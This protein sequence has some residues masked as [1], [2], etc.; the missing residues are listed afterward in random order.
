MEHVK[1]VRTDQV[2]EGFPMDFDCY[3]KNCEP[4]RPGSY[5][6]VILFAK[7]TETK[8]GDGALLVSLGV[9]R[10]GDPTRDAQEDGGMIRVDAM[11]KNGTSWLDNYMEV[12]D[13]KNLHG[14]FDPRSHRAM[15]VLVEMDVE[16]Y[17]NKDRNKVTRF[18]KARK[19]N[20]ISSGNGDRQ[21]RG[22]KAKGNPFDGEEEEHGRGR[23][24]EPVRDR[25]RD[26]EERRRRDERG[27]RYDEDR[28]SRRGGEPSG[29]YGK[30]YGGG[31]SST[32]S[33]R[34]DGDLPF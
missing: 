11:L 18:L 16:T 30:T 34:N 23:G 10:S 1:G 25:D 7:E 28:G 27:Q 15:I 29:G 20:S 6:A 17:D 33:D 4:M 21:D 19:P 32:K 26:E 8:K 14:T 9:S 3:T 5:K 22:G 31:G 2:V 13:P 24:R 12:V